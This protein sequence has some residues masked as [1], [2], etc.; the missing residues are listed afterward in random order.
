MAPDPWFRAYESASAE[1]ARMHTG[2]RHCWCGD[3]AAESLA[4]LERSIDDHT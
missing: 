3:C 1:G 4:S 2:A